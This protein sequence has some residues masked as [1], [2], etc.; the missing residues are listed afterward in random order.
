M[1]KAISILGLSC[2]GA[3]TVSAKHGKWTYYWITFESDES[4]SGSRDTQLKTCNGK[5]IAS[6]TR[7]YAE[8]VR[9][10][11]TGKLRDGRVVNLGDCDCGSGFKCFESYDAGRFPWGMGSND[12]AIYP[13][14][15]VASND[16]KVGTKLYIP[17]LKGVS[18]PGTSQKHDG[19][20]QVDDKAWSFGSNHIDFFVGHEKN[21]DTLDHQLKINSVD[22]EVSNCH[23]QRYGLKAFKTSNVEVADYRDFEDDNDDDDEHDDEDFLDLPYYDGKVKYGDEQDQDDNEDDDDNKDDDNDDDN[24]DDDNDDDFDIYSLEHEWVQ[25]Q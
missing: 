25:G 22:Y 24:N 17:A 14:S 11:G 9:M 23:P 3:A 5:T 8:R 21:Y 13:Y 10:E 12:N 4:G 19:C 1:R 15:S 18:M 16:F 20:V 2:L 6:V 7:H